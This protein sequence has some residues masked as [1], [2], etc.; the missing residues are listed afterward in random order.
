MPSYTKKELTK[1]YQISSETLRRY[2]S[3]PKIFP[4]LVEKGYNKHQKKLTPAMISL[5]FDFL[6]TP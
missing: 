2:L 6:G 1:L 4:K 3:S 5:I